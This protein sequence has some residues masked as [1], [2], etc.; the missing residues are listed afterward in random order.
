MSFI[1]MG[2]KQLLA[3]WSNNNLK[4]VR[5]LV[6]KALVYPHLIMSGIHSES[7]WEKETKYWINELGFNDFYG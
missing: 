4:I 2:N 1:F 6:G 5:A 7:S 3:R